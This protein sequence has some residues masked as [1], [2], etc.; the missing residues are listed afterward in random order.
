M[1]SDLNHGKASLAD[2]ALTE[3]LGDTGWL[4]DC[5]PTHLA[6]FPWR[7]HQATQ[8]P[9]EHVTAGS[10][11]GSGSHDPTNPARRQRPCIYG[12]STPMG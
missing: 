9:F 1:Q 7:Q 5:L 8:S 12:L 6:A 2:N 4:R 11:P 3:S 10:S